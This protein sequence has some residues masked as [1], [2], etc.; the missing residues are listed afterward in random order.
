MAGRLG[1]AAAARAAAAHP[2]VPR[3][4][5]GA[6]SLLYKVHVRLRWAHTVVIEPALR[7]PDAW[8]ALLPVPQRHI[9]QAH[10]WP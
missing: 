2:A 6:V 5:Q 9:V 4:P 10:A 3:L 7:W 1:A 8:E